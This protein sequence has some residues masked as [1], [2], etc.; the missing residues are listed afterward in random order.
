MSE[1]NNLCPGFIECMKRTGL[2][3][4][5]KDHKAFIEGFIDEEDNPHRLVGDDFERCRQSS[6]IIEYKRGTCIR[7]DDKTA[8]N[9]TI[10]VNPNSDDDYRNFTDVLD[11][12]LEALNRTEIDLKS[13]SVRREG[14]SEGN[15]VYC[16]Q[17]IFS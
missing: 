3:S 9:F 1:Q 15:N 17:L 13:I 6:Q 12:L 14:E 16:L 10:H 4:D 8:Y 7:T 11:N 2:F 5:W